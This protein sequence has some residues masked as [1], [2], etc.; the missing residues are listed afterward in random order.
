MTGVT[1]ANSRDRA[2]AGRAAGAKLERSEGADDR[3]SARAAHS[4]ADGARMIVTVHPSYLL[5]IPDAGDKRAQ[6]RLFVRD[7]RLCIA[8]N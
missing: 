2:A 3:E 4:L 7:L 8:A 5:R 1:V 6:Y